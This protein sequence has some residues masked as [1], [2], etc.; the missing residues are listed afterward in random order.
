MNYWNFFIES[1][2]VN[3]I[4]YSIYCKMEVNLV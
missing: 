4:L 1:I 3:K 2:Q